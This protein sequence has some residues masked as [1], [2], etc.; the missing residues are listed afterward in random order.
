MP[1]YRAENITVL[2]G[3]EA[4]RKRPSMYI[5]STGERGLHHLVYEVVD[6]SVDEALAGHCDTIVVTLLPGGGRPRRR[7][8]SRNPDRHCRI[9][10]QAGARGRLDGAPCG[11]QVRRRGLRRL[12]RTPRR[13]RLRGQ[14]AVV[15]ARGGGQAR[16]TRL[17]PGLRD[18]RA[19]RPR[20]EGRGDARAPAP[21]SPS[22]RT[23][24]S[25]RRRTTTTRPFGRVSSRWP[26]S[27]AASRSP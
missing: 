21:R 18:R 12:R 13:R 22:G 15:A 20:Q 9:G 26:S 2:E 23:T 7:Q 5:G 24:R 6:N 4:V 11:R 14:R 8:R 3:L 25:S 16:G 10:G 17:A 27:T 1:S 19:P